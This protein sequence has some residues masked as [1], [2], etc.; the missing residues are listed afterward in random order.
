MRLVPALAGIAATTSASHEYFRIV[1]IAVMDIKL[2]LGGASPTVTGRVS[3]SVPGLQG[4][5]GPFCCSPDGGDTR[6]FTPVLD[7]LWRRNPGRL[8]ALRWRS[9]RATRC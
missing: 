3:E 6:A 5:A 8:P 4:R 7:G 2:L 9:M 1:R